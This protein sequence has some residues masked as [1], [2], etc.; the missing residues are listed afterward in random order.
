MSSTRSCLPEWALGQLFDQART[1]SLFTSAPVSDDQ[2]RRLHE[3]MRWGPT[4]FN[5]QPA[6]LL[7][8]RSQASRERLAA[9]VA[10]GNRVKV[11]SAAVSVVLASDS[12]FVQTLPR[13]S[14]HPGAPAL[15]AKWPELIEPTATGS[16]T[17]QAAYLLFAARA[18]G[19]DTGMLTGFDAAAVAREFFE[20]KPWRPEVVINLGVGDDTRLP[21]R[22]AR[23]GFDEVARIL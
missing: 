7:F 10:P 11:M 2:L 3:L 13:F 6:R 8:L 12:G 16:A 20:G 23:F 9:C 18:I 15:F 19:L 22:A 1:Y 17:L 21:T 14:D 5:S 4:A